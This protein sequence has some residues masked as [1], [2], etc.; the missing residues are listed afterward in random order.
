MS[1]VVVVVMS[2]VLV[3]LSAAAFGG[4][5]RRQLSATSSN[6]SAKRVTD[7]L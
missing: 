7:R 2:D 4:S 3:G 6:M 1:V 5:F